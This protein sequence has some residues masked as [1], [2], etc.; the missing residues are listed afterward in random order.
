MA[1]PASPLPLFDLFLDVPHPAAS[2]SC[3]K[4][5]WVPSPARD[6]A[7]MEEMQKSI[8]QVA[9]FAF[10]EYDQTSAPPASG[11]SPLNRYDYHAMQNTPFLQ[12][13]FSLQL[14]TGARMHGHV[15]RYLPPHLV[16]RSRY[17]VGRRGERALV[18]LTRAAGADSLYASILKSLQAISYHQATMP[19]YQQAHAEPQK[20]LLHNLVNHQQH[21]ARIYQTRPPEQ[22]G[23]PL[24]ATL[25][26][27]ELGLSVPTFTSVDL[28]RYL[29]PTALLTASSSQSVA[30]ASN[31]ILPLLRCVGVAHALRILSAL[32]SERR[33]IM[34]SHSPTRLA[35]C[36][37]AALAMLAQG[38]LQ[39]QHL[40]IPVMPP[41]LWQYLAAPY[42][43]LIG[44][45][46]PV[47]S[48]LDYTDGLGDVLIIHLDTNNMETRGMDANTV[49]QRIPDL[50]MTTVKGEF[51]S[52]RQM[53][54]QLGSGA[55]ATPSECLAQELVDIVKADKKAMYGESALANM[56][57]TAAKATKAVKTTLNK[58]KNKGKMFLQKKGSSSNQDSNDVE[59]VEEVEVQL[60][61][62]EA[63]DAK[64]MAPDYIYVE[65][66]HN[67]AAEEEAR[68]SFTIFFLCMFGDVRW[69]LSV[70]PGDSAA[71]LDR[72]KYLA[73]K[74]SAGEGEGTPIWP[75]LQNFCQTQM[76]AE[77]VSRRVEEIRNRQPLNTPDTPL[78]LQC[79]YYHRRHQIDF[80]LLDVRKVCRQLAQ[81]SLSRRAAAVQS[82]ARRTAMLLTSNKPFEG[83][84]AKAVAQ[85]VEEC[86]ECSTILADVMS[87]L[88]LRIRDSR[89]MQWKHGYQAL[90]ILRNLLYHGPTAVIAEA[91]DGLD[92]IRAMKNYENMRGQIVQQ[93]RNAAT[94]VYGLLVDRSRLFNV[95]RVCAQRRWQ[96]RNNA[97]PRL[98]RDQKLWFNVPFDTMH[99]AMHPNARGTIV[100]IP[101]ITDPRGAMANTAPSVPVPQVND[102]LLGI[103]DSMTVSQPTVPVASSNPFDTV[104]KPDPPEVANQH[105]YVTQQ[106]PGTVPSGAGLIGTAQAPI[107][108]DTTYQPTIVPVPAAQPSVV[109]NNAA[110]LAHA[111]STPPQVPPSVGPVY[112]SAGI[113]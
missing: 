59:E 10:P 91:T 75:L 44:I 20:W 53:V 109:A 8:P 72:N 81:S 12:F 97:A 83:D 29:I 99:A 106:I 38:M 17:D 68:I 16:A 6:D 22:Q 111:P 55:P 78:F 86:L 13:T 2:S 65:S 5:F 73:H 58:I 70:S 102:D 41:H 66:C 25:E 71:V 33:V 26:G 103:F 85:L 64:S 94:D 93:V 98:T 57:E 46:S 87:V 104:T 31:S 92:K 96:L 82:N 50:F 48:R 89:G 32:L 30:N 47:V 100:N 28:N 49:N 95:R 18:I 80:G 7:L 63:P 112:N 45:L 67:E 3:P 19:P 84:Y 11:A 62:T 42:P 52:P 113:Q 101:P 14:S 108:V 40:Y 88:W 69:Y 43:Y 54:N 35:A 23:V 60:A 79:C 76:L 34:V 21:L 15:R 90:M 27:L 56:G 1:A 37:H 107:Q 4:P 110:P 24:L 74:R 61:A 77:F 9:S 36:S 39:W 51:S 105:L